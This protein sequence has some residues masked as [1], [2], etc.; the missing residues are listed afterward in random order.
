MLS[1][2]ESYG[3]TIHFQLGFVALDYSEE[4]VDSGHN[5]S[6]KSTMWFQFN[7]KNLYQQPDKTDC[8]K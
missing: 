5:I 2:Q 6:T 8:K 1:V 7:E 3:T 4:N